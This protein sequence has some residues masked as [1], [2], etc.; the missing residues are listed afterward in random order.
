MLHAQTDGD[1]PL[2]ANTAA[3]W[4]ASSR[5]GCA[6]KP[7]LAQAALAAPACA[8]QQ[9]EAA[10]AASRRPP[11]IPAELTRCNAP[12][13]DIARDFHAER[14][15]RTTLQGQPAQATGWAALP[16]LGVFG[17]WRLR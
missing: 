5:L 16:G 12:L 4:R 1:P 7:A 9:V 2:S 17:R 15:A 14:E 10:Y 8:L 11:N 13:N 3:A 6:L